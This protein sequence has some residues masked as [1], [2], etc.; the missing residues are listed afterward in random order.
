MAKNNRADLIPGPVW[1]EPAGAPEE[2][3]PAFLLRLIHFD[4]AKHLETIGAM[5]VTFEAGSSR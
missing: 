2:I 3:P 4:E 5:R 1:P